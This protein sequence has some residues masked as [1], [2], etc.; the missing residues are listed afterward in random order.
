MVVCPPWDLFDDLCM[1]I[2]LVP[3]E[4]SGALIFLKLFRHEK[5]PGSETSHKTF[6]ENLICARSSAK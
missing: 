3:V 5:L 6:S 4:V 2:S 1:L